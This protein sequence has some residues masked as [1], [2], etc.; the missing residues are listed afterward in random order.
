MKAELLDSLI[1]N[2]IVKE[3]TEVTVFRSGRD[4]AGMP[5]VSVRHQME[6]T[7][8]EVIEKQTLLEAISVVDG[9]RFN[10]QAKHILQVD[11][12]NPERLATAFKTE[13]KKRGRKA[14]PKKK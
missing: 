12:M 6:I 11:G 3:G 5:T 7:K 13:G 2:G 9:K 14:N 4:I 1:N 8:M 10:I